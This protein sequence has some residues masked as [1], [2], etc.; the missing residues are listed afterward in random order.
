MTD[1]R[2]AQDSIQKPGPGSGLASR[3][4]AESVAVGAGFGVDG[5]RG[6]A[7]AFVASPPVAA[8]GE[9]EALGAATVAGGAGLKVNPAPWRRGPGTRLPPRCPSS[10]GRG[11]RRPRDGWLQRLP[12]RESPPRRRRTR[13]RGGALVVRARSPRSVRRRPPVARPGAPPRVRKSQRVPRRPAAEPPRPEPRSPPLRNQGPTVG[14]R[15][16]TARAG[17]GRARA[18][19]SSRALSQGQ[20]AADR[21]SAPRELPASPRTSAHPESSLR[22]A[23]RLRR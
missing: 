17:G 2:A 11:E 9:F 6:F 18:R 13:A 7:F 19:G 16:P 22:P 12:K 10:A 21:R 1:P 15:S 5:L 20:G 4:T 23:R 3:L 8:A 14:D